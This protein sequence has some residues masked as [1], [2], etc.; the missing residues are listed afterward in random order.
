MKT[1]SM[2]IARHDST[3]GSGE[4]ASSF[5][6]PGFGKLVP[7]QDDA[8][9]FSYFKD[10]LSTVQRIPPLPTPPESA[11]TRPTPLPN[12]A[13][14]SGKVSPEQIRESMRALDDYLKS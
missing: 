3:I 9:D 8:G 13:F 14:K 2:K 12:A 5:E 10:A 11:T 6:I 7:D 4:P 1:E